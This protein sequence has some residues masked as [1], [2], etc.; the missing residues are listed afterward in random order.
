[1]LA[2]S[3]AS[4]YTRAVLQCVIVAMLSTAV[5]FSSVVSV[6]SDYNVILKATSHI[7]FIANEHLFVCGCVCM[8]PTRIPVDMHI[9]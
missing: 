5:G 8:S 4:F 2:S 9:Q 3:V 6:Q 7:V 1:M